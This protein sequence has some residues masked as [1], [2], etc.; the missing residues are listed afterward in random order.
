MYEAKYQTLMTAAGRALPCL[1]CQGLPRGRQAQ[2]RPPAAARHRLTFINVA[3]EAIYLHITDNTL[4]PL[5]SPP[6]PALRFTF[7]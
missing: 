5:L 4:S 6:K 3:G 2:R 1:A 7:I